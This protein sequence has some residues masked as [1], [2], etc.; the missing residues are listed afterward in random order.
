MGR[1]CVGRRYVSRC[2]ASRRCVSRRCGSHRCV[3]C[4]CVSRR[5]VSHCCVSRRCVTGCCVS[6][7]FV[8]RHFSEH[9]IGGSTYHPMDPFHAS[10]ALSLFTHTL[11]ELLALFWSALSEKI[12]IN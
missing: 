6:H 8:S 3:T 1:R 7:H 12:L 9:F 10:L 2:C 5:C 4:C 11:L